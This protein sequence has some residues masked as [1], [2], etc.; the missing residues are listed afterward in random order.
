M[1]QEYIGAIVIV[2]VSIFK[3]FGIEIQNEVLAG[4]L[5]GVIGVWVAVRRYQKKDINLLGKRV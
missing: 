2:L 4:L 1:S 5:T 3:M